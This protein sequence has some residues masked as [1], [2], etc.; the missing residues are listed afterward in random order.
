M[1]KA[2]GQE[3]RYVN[4]VRFVTVTSE[5]EKANIMSSKVKGIVLFQV[6]RPIRANEEISVFFPVT[7]E[8]QNSVQTPLPTQLHSPVPG[9]NQLPHGLPLPYSTG[10]H[11]SLLLHGTPEVNM[12]SLMTSTPVFHPHKPAA[13]TDLSSRKTLKFG[14]NSGSSLTPSNKPDLQDKN[15]LEHGDLRGHDL[16]QD[17]IPSSPMF[18]SC[19]SN[20]VTT[21]SDDTTNLSDDVRVTEEEEED[22]K[23]GD[24]ECGGINDNIEMKREVEREEQDEEIEEEHSE[25]HSSFECE[26]S[27]KSSDCNQCDSGICKEEVL[28][29]LTSQESDDLL[30]SDVHVMGKEYNIPDSEE[31]SR[32]EKKGQFSNLMNAFILDLNS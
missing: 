22:K 31:K 9:G 12:T 17:S 20:E 10:L 32:C 14:S 5:P 23:R 16:S 4:W 13:L 1:V 24:E 27:G 21:R 7:S 29:G 30:T 11:S 18:A 6:I 25:R 8:R 26:K 15:L 2:E 19:S 28:A 3:V